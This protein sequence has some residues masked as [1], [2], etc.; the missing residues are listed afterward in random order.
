MDERDVMNAF[1]SHLGHHKGYA[2]LMVDR[3]PEDEN[4]QSPEID[5]I[6]GPFAIEHTSIDSVA[7]Q[8]RANDWFSRVVSG[9]DRV[10]DGCVDCGFTITLEFDAITTGM[11]WNCIRGDLERWILGSASRLGHGCHMI[12]LPTS[13]PVNSPILMTV[14]KGQ[15]RVIG[16]SRIDPCDNSLATR[17]RSLLDRKAFKLMKYRTPDTTTILLVENDDIALMNELK[18]LDAIRDAY[19]NGL[20]RGVDEIWFADTTIPDK[21]R[22]RDFTTEIVSSCQRPSPSQ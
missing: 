18:M 2:N 15:P 10:I 16:F 12:T 8:R 11:D 5:A 7:D 4:R 6:A 22:F 3:W 14:W 17:T 1:I 19:P 13:T 21:L 9:L 20:P